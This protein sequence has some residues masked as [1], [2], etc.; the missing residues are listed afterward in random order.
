[1]AK[2]IITEIRKNTR[3]KFSA[4]EKI[5]IVVEGL[6]GEI[7]IS[8]FVVARRSVLRNIT[9]GPSSSWRLVRTR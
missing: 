2:N 8:D 1:M 5:R 9:N 4:D 3:R 7:P 6:R